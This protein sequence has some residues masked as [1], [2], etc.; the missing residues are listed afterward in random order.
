MMPEKIDRILVKRRAYFALA[1]TYE[2]E[3]EGE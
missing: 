1:G 3:V 2:G